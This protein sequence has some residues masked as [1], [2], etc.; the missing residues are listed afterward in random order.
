MISTVLLIILGIAAAL[1]LIAV[2]AS[3]TFTAEFA[4]SDSSR[5]GNFMIHWMHPRVACLTY[6]IGSRCGVLK[7]LGWTR[8]LYKKEENDETQSGRATPESSASGRAPEPLR[9][10]PQACPSEERA[11]AQPDA[12]G[13][14]ASDKQRQETPRDRQEAAPRE[15]RM[16]GWQKIKTVYSILDR[17]H[18]PARA[19]R[20]CSRVVRLSFRIVR[21]DHFRLHAKAG[22][23]DP[24]ETGKF[25]GWY[26][27]AARGLFSRQKKFDPRV[28]VR[29]E[30]Q[31]S[32][33]AL[34]I[35]GSMGLRTSIARAGVMAGVAFITFPY[36]TAYVVWRRIKKLQQR[37]AV[38]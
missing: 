33:D 19:F 20:W 10:S 31:F 14:V 30:P 13:Q 32:G 2:C 15:K 27:A 12:P 26:V 8:T 6:T 9:Q 3:I 7:I 23:A 28:D 25:Y 34:E 38:A 11:A 36:Y 1:F 24:A 37:T 35:E 4:Y 21:F 17:Q 5:K 29:F 18:V 16:S 22:A